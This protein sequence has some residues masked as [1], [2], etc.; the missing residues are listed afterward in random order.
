MP[1]DFT[2]IHGLDLLAARAD[3]VVV[4]M[5]SIRVGPFVS[6]RFIAEVYLHEDAQLGECRKTSV[7]SH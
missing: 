7:N 6:D 5:I 2:E 1:C 4:M 3:N